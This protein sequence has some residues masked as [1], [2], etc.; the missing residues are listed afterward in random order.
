MLFNISHFQVLLQIN[1][2]KR[3]TNASTHVVSGHDHLL[4]TRSHKL[5]QRIWLGGTHVTWDLE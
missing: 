1:R 5:V 4:Q 3:Q 2:E